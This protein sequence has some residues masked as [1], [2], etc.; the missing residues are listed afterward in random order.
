MIPKTNGLISHDYSCLFHVDDFVVFSVN[1]S[2]NNAI[3][4]LNVLLYSL[5]SKL[6]SAFFKVTPNKS[7][8]IDYLYQ[9][10]I[11]ELPAYIYIYVY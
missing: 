4:H 1:K 5:N 9:K 6:S 8:S 2:L 11:R 10:T 7:Q 3:L